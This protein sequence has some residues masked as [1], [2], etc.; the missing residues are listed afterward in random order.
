MSM[1]ADTKKEKNVIVSEV[2]QAAGTAA[3]G[4]DSLKHFAANAFSSSSPLPR[5]VIFNRGCASQ[6]FAR[7]VASYVGA[8]QR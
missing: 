6:H 7:A 1:K 2:Q 4:A 3:A 8:A 5:H